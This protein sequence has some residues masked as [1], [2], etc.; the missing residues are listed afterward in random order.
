MSGS[1]QAKDGYS[2]NVAAWR[3]IPQ[4][5]CPAV[6]RVDAA[7]I[8]RQ[9]G[10]AAHGARRVWYQVTGVQGDRVRFEVQCLFAASGEELV[11]PNELRFR[12]PRGTDVVADRRRLPGGACLR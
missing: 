11:F 10:D 1:A 4:P 12:T 2:R 8:R 7:S 9:A 3:S 6:D 5:A